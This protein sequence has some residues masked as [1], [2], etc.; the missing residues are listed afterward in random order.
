MIYEHKGVYIVKSI[1]KKIP[2][3]V[4]ALVVA[5]CSELPPVNQNDYRDLDKEYG[6]FKTQA[7]TKSYLTRKMQKLLT[8]PVNGD[9]LVKEINYA[10]FKY[11]QL[12]VDV[13]TGIPGMY[14]KIPIT[15]TLPT[16]N[17]S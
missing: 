16:G 6:Q 2:V 15:S 17:Y 5:G 1:L 10:R 11:R 4:L 8:V 12:L 14:G 3:I 7:L 9:N 13:V